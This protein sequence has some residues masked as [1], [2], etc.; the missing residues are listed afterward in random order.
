M[1]NDMNGEGPALSKRELTLIGAGL[2]GGAAIGAVV[3][4]VTGDVLAMSLMPGAGLF[5]SLV[6]VSLYR[7]GILRME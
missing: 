3:L 2:V 7:R 4:A 5:I 6:Y 1:T